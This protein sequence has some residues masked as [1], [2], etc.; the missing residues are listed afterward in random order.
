MAE[1]R[2]VT[3][4]SGARVP[5]LGQGTWHMGDDPARR[6]EEVRA[7]R[8]GLDL[9]MTLIDTAEMYGSGAAEELVG[10]AVRGR[11]DDVFLVSK[12]LPSHADTRGTVDAC[13]AS[14][15][16]LGTDRIDLYL[17]HWRGSVPLRE[18]VEAFERLVSEGSI[19]SWG[20]SNLDTDDLAELPDGALPATDQVLYNLTRRGPEYDLIPRCRELAV[21]VMAYSPV[22]QGRLL[23]HRAL[24][25]VATAHGK[26]T[27][28]VALA[29]VLRHDDVIAIPKASTVAHVEENRAALDL[30]LTAEDFDALD[31]AFP[32]P[33]RK[34]PLDVL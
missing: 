19:G 14:L 29:W 8:R 5:A 33:T 28:Q 22:E 25:A 11:R 24:A 7:L 3:L 27:A 2:T 26:S 1:V 9:G 32:P 16:R 30:R 23:G 10:E 20:V 15:R 34:Q 17:L 13:H 4:P 31:R 6:A 21:P 18:T 12:V